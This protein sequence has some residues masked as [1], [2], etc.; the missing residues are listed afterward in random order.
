[1]SKAE[2]K[3][4]KKEK[5]KNEADHRKSTAD[6]KILKDIPKRNLNAAP[7]EYDFNYLVSELFL[8]EPFLG[9]ILSTLSRREDWTVPTAYV[10]VD[11]RRKQIMFGYNPEFLRS[12][13]SN[14]ERKYVFK[15]ELY[16]VI[17]KHV[18]SRRVMDKKNHPLWNIATDL[19]INGGILTE[20]NAPE[21][22]LL[23]GVAPKNCKD[24][25]L[26]ALIQSFPK[27]ESSDFYYA[28]LK[29]YADSINKTGDG[30]ADIC[31]SIGADGEGSTMDGHGDWNDIPEEIRELIEERLKGNMHNA[32]RKARTEGWGSVPA[33][34]QEV[35]TKMFSNQV[36]WKSVLRNFIGSCRSAQR[37]STIKKVNKKAPYVFPGI[38]R[39]TIAKLV[40][41]I[42][43]SG[44]MSDEDV[45]RSFAAAFEC[46]NETEIECFNFDTEVDE[47]SH[48]IWK[49]G[50]DQT[51]MRTR[52]GGTDFD[53]VARFVN[54]PQNK[55]KWTG[56]VICTDGYAPEMGG[57]Y[58]AKVL[59][60]ITPEGTMDT[61]RKGD[62]VIRL[63]KDNVAKKA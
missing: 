56:V 14:D 61:V 46:S 40:F 62:L 18:T 19:C 42:D 28:A 8:S 23:P 60:L 13:K 12:L 63:G 44:S 45:Q 30:V 29:S 5:N 11:V 22:C 39:K 4:L 47:N 24:P 49:R 17:L 58:G 15:H 34:I 7:G 36:D 50:M 31:I 51:W 2:E 26:S 41:F 53:A 27:N 1:M 33:E 35:I 9:Y 3:E 57:I 59:W 21:L 55:N 52:S 16:H 25:N 38:K 6:N 48:Q 20:K 32:Y 37:E 54:S 10:G 43:Q